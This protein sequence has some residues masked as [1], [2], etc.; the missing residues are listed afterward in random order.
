MKFEP[1]GNIKYYLAEI[2]FNIQGNK[3][4]SRKCP[5]GAQQIETVR[6]EYM[7]PDLRVWQSSFAQVSLSNICYPQSTEVDKYS[8]ENSRRCK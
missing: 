1:R 8:M 3:S 2:L 6:K 7:L 5:E 4:R